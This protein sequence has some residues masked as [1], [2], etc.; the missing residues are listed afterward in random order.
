MRSRQQ[1]D[2]A[3]EKGYRDD[4][5]S[6]KWPVRV[7]HKISIVKR[8]VFTEITQWAREKYEWG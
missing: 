2:H 4:D 5:D 7:L 3:V 6:D 1:S 8:E